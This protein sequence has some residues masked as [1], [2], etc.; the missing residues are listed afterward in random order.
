MKFSTEQF[1]AINA[2]VANLKTAYS[3][4][5]VVPAG[6]LSKFCAPAG[7]RSMNVTTRDGNRILSI[8]N[9]LLEIDCGYAP[10]DVQPTSPTSG[11]GEVDGGLRMAA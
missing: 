4:V 5:S 6:A 1:S 7:V 11:A 9:G 8:N 10:E 2:A 3:E